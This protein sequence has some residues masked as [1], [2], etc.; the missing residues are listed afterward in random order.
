MNAGVREYWMI[1]PFKKNVVVY[2][3]EHEEYPT[4]YGFDAI[5]PVQIWNG[6]CAI[7]FQ[8]VYEHIRFLYK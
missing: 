8:E 6:K 4:I 1:D 3:F 7:D 5:I 2:D